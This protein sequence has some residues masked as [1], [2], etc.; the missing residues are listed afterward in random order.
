MLHTLFERWKKNTSRL[1]RRVFDEASKAWNFINYILQNYKEYYCQFLWSFWL[2]IAFKLN[3]I[4]CWCKLYC[5]LYF[6]CC[7]MCPFCLFFSCKEKNLTDLKT[8][9][10]KLFSKYLSS[11][12]G[13]CKCCIWSGMVQWRK[14]TPDR[15]WRPNSC[16][17]WCGDMPEAGHFPRTCKQ[18][19]VNF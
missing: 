8:F 18:R 2:S 14:Q 16:A 13:S 15:L 6:R 1:E 7:Y 10:K 3:K 11:L 12:A 17:V 19:Q 5:T 4:I 9:I